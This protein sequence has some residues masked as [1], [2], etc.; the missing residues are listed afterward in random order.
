MAKQNKQ[1]K[2]GGTKQSNTPRWRTYKPIEVKLPRPKG[3]K[4]GKSQAER[5]LEAYEIK[6]YKTPELEVKED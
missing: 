4:R 3:G 2:R 1:A 6:E 5:N